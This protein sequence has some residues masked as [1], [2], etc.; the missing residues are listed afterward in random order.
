MGFHPCLFYT[1]GFSSFGISDSF[2]S[3]FDVA[4]L[5]SIGRRIHP[6]NSDYRFLALVPIVK[7]TTA[8]LK[9]E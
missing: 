2:F 9:S 3:I 4:S 7:K 1:H 6:L 8:K 5:A